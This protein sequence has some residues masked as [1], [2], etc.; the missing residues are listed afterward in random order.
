MQIR[1]IIS[2]CG[3]LFVMLLA[4]LTA[5][6][7]EAPRAPGTQGG[8]VA[9]PG[10]VPGPAAP[11]L[12]FREAWQQRP[13][14]QQHP[15]ASDVVSNPNLVTGT[16]T[17]PLGVVWLFNGLATTRIAVTLRHKDSDVD[18]SGAAKIRWTIRTSGFHVVR[19]V[20]KLA[21]GTWLIGDRA[22]VS[23]NYFT[24]VEFSPSTIRWL[25]LDI[26]RVVTKNQTNGEWIDKPDLTK[27][28][29]VGYADLI[30]GSGHGFGG[31]ASLGPIAVYGMPVRR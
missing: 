19:P 5:Q 1:R 26:D 14:G 9:V 7:P 3:V 29:E 21:D 2:G 6:Q 17:G 18:L 16:S 10:R 31:W 30:P 23:P 13:D 8:A 20:V 12:F 27:V 11:P 22:D 28:D 15:V 4:V 24:E 25:P